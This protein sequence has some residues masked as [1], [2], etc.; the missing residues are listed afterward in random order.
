MSTTKE[1]GVYFIEREE[2]ERLPRVNWSKLKMF[3]VSPAHYRQAVLEP[4]EDTDPMK[5]GRACHLAVYEP[6]QFQARCVVWRGKVRNGGAWDDFREAHADDEI[7]TVHQHETALAVGRAVRSSAMAAPY[8]SGGQGE[9]TLLWRSGDVDLKSRLD[10]VA[11]VGAI[12]DLKTVNRL[13]GAA[14]KTFGRT[15]RNMKYGTQAATYRRAYHSVTGKLLPYFLIA[16]ETM[17]PFAVQVYR[18]TDE[19][20]EQGEQHL[21]QLLETYRGCRDRSV[22]Q[23]YANEVMPLEMP[24][25]W[26]EDGVEDLGIDFGSAGVAPAI[27]F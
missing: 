2:Y 9:V 19:Q 13:G 18:L 22:W 12:A 23:Q 14:P 15:A 16:A 7:L 27:G 26:S 1:P 6:E 11:E 5:L 17:A 3:D 20:L 21:E 8:I 24:L 10:W 25:E 4:F